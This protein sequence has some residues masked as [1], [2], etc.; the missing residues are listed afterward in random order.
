MKKLALVA[1][2]L[3]MAGRVFAADAYKIDSAHSNIGFSIKHMMV[4]NTTGQFGKFDG[5]IA[6]SPEDLAGS[7]VSVTIPVASINTANEQRD[8][9]LKSPDFFDAAKFPEITFVS[10][11]IAKDSITGDLTIKGVTKAVTIPVTIDG[12]VKGMMGKDV[13]GI[14]GTF[15][16]NRQDYGLTWNKTL[17]QG[18]VAIADEVNVTVSIEAGKE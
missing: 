16:L 5:T 6:Y 4:S 12:P 17:D 15:K 8:G 3:L 2:G 11:S 9:H 18:G 13:I 1:V 7:K 10:K 14:N